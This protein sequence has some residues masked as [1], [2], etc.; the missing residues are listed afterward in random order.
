MSS[1]PFSGTVVIQ[2][3]GAI[4][5]LAAAAAKVAGAKQVIMTGAPDFRLRMGEEVGVVDNT[6]N[7]T[8]TGTEERIKEVR[9]LTSGRY[10]TD[11]VIEVAGTP[12]ALLEAIEMVRKARTIVEAG[13]FT[14]VGRTI[15]INVCRQLC[16]KDLTLH[17]VYGPSPRH[18][19]KSFY[20]LQGT[21]DRFPYEKI[22]THKFSIDHASRA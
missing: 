18:F 15:Q 10:G 2:G 16:A 7:I 22:V 6:I 19:E 21:M 14:D 5:I 9:K 8:K 17:N 20:M 3:S 1:C 4:G 12:E 13:N 11:I